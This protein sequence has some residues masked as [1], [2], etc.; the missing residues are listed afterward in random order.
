[1]AV[2]AAEAGIDVT[3]IADVQESVDDKG[4][5]KSS[6]QAADMELQLSCMLQQN[7]N[8]YDIAECSKKLTSKKNAGTRK[9]PDDFASQLKSQV[10]YL[11][12]SPPNGNGCITFKREP[13]TSRSIDFEDGRGESATYHM[14]QKLGFQ[15]AL[16]SKLPPDQGRQSRARWQTK[17]ANTLHRRSGNR[18]F[19]IS[20]ATAAAPQHLQWKGNFCSPQI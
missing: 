19:C 3:I 11:A 18:R 13:L 10:T 4:K 5:E 8:K 7:R 1:M 14:V 16:W 6:L 12:E 2:A 15:Y 17:Q 20:N 9:L